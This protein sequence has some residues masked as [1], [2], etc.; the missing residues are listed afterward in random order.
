MIDRS[1]QLFQTA[2]YHPTHFFLGNQLKI[3]LLIIMFMSK[4]CTLIVTTLFWEANIS[5]GARML[6][7]LLSHMGLRG[8]DALVSCEKRVF[9]H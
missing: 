1:T 3:I 9:T 8:P 4:P 7:L 5:P 6:P 2:D